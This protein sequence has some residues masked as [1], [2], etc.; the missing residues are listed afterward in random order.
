MIR[1]RIFDIPAALTALCPG[2]QWVHRGTDYGGLEWLDQNQTKPT[3]EEVEAEIVRLQAE[4]DAQQYQRLR[5]EA[6]PP[7]AD[8]LDILYHGGFDAWRTAID[9]IKEQFPKPLP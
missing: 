9:E 8:Q 1:E 3:Q 5:K 7:I 6:Y 4:Y 2:A